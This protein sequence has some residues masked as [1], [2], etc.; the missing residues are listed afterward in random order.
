MKFF[1]NT[2]CLEKSII[3]VTCSGHGKKEVN[4]QNK[5]MPCKKL[6]VLPVGK[7]EFKSKYQ[8]YDVLDTKKTYCVKCP[9]CGAYTELNER[10]IPEAVKR[11]VNLKLVSDQYLK[12]QKELSK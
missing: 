10:R 7:I 8:G 11:Y 3:K 6:I 5:A 12:S 1:I 4:N 2:T 9:N